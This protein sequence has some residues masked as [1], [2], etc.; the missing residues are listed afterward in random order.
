MINRRSAAAGLA[1]LPFGAAA[2]Q[3]QTSRLLFIGNSLTY[4]HS[5]PLMV[6]ALLSAQGRDVDVSDV[7]RP[8]YGLQDHWQGR[9]ARGAITRHP[10]NWVVLQQGPS[11]LPE[12]R[13][14]LR[15]YAGRFND[16]IVARGARCALYSTWPSAYRLGDFERAIESYAIVAA[17]L[18]AMLLPVAAAWRAALIRDNA[19][20]LYSSDG[21]HPTRYGAYLA[22]LVIAGRLEGL[23]PS[24]APPE[25]ELSS[26]RTIRLDAGVAATLQAVAAGTLDETP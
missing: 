1:A 25:F 16:M 4:T 18:G 6:Q 2:A 8:D 10:W 7:A 5:L 14:D 26:G 13:E 24:S 19:L 11:S 9:G 15:R 17:E 23:A 20:P 3:S 21:L 22:A 12:S